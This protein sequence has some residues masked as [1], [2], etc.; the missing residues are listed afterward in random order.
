MTCDK[1]N[2]ANKDTFCDL[3]TDY[4]IEL[5]DNR[6]MIIEKLITVAYQNKFMK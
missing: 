4:N 1:H 5:T 6:K 2:C 3:C